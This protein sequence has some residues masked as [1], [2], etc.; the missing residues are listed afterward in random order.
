MRKFLWPAALILAGCA[1]PPREEVPP[2]APAPAEKP[3]APGEAWTVM[4][5]LLDV[6]VYRDGAVITL[7]YFMTLVSAVYVGAFVVLVLYAGM[8]YEQVFAIMRSWW[9]GL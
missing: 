8:N 1:I 7:G 3:A 4:H 6:H 2:T 5:S 9:A